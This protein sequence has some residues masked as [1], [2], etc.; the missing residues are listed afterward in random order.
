MNNF[1]LLQMIL[2]EVIVFH[3]F[4]MRKVTFLVHMCISFT[5]M[6]IS[7]YTNVETEGIVILGT[8]WQ[9]SPLNPHIDS[10][11]FFV[12]LKFKLRALCML[13]KTFAEELYSPVLQ[14]I[15]KIVVKSDRLAYLT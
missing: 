2:Y 13:G 4:L 12:V 6:H 9:L 1:R 7:L 8:R 5:H 10:L 14:F 15:W 3:L 11:A